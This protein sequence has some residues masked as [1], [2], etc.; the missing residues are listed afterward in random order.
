MTRHRL[1]DAVVVVTG[2]TAGVGRAAARAFATEGA[3][4]AVLARGREGL[5][6]TRHEL[7]RKGATVLPVRADVADAEA[8]EAAAERVESVLGPIRVWVNNAMTSVLSRVWDTTPAEF[9][10]VMEVTCLGQVHGASS[11]LA[12]MRARNAGTIVFVGS[13]LAKRGIPLQASYCA[14]KHATQGYFESLRCELLA[15]G[16]GVHACMVHLPA[17]NTPQFR[18]VKSRMA[19]ESQPLPPI[20]QPEVA[21]DAIVHV[22]LHPRREVY[23]GAP[24]IKTI[25]GNR[26]VPWLADRYLAKRGIAGQLTSE[27][28]QREA[29]NLWEPV[30]GDR[31]SHGPFDEGARKRSWQW[32][33]DKHRWFAGSSALALAGAGAA[34][35]RNGRIGGLLRRS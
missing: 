18:W 5:E 29:H 1:K 19:H 33:M 31:G 14:A 35:A 17:L 4:V 13:A 26:L 6:A 12:R 3:R 25:W 22:A 2:G 10:R 16:S 15:E 27:V 32:L 21:A 28:K 34:W 20:F 8:V 9:R 11:A 23:V 30:E 24:T 7:E